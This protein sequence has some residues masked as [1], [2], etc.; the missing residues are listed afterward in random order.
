MQSLKL[1]LNPGLKSGHPALEFTNTVSNHASEHPG[2]TLFEYA[3]L[4]SWAGKVGLLSD[5]QVQ[6][7]RRR[8]ANHD[9]CKVT[10]TARGDL[11]DLRCADARQ[12]RGRK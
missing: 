12:A 10:G 9:L 11:S 4:L 3:D 6:G 1:G 2:E 8:A 5:E 7:L